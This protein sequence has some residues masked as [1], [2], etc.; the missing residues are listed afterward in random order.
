MEK[1]AVSGIML[2]MLLIGMLTLAFNT[3][4]V[5]ASGTIYIRAD[6]SIEPSDAPISVMDNV[7]YILTDNI[8]SS[9]DG[10]VVERN[11]ILIDGRSCV[12][13]GTGSG[14]GISLFH[15]NNVTIRNVTIKAFQYG[16]LLNCSSNS[17][18]AENFIIANDVAGIKLINSSNNKIERNNLLNNFYGI[19]LLYAS[20]NSISRNNLL[21][22]LSAILLCSS[23]DNKITENEIIANHDCSIWIGDSSNNFVA[24]NNIAANKLYGIWIVRS[25]ENILK[26]NNITSN[27]YGIWS[28]Y[29]SNNKFYHNNFINNTKQ[30]NIF[31]DGKNIWDDGYPSGG[32]Y[33]SDYTDCDFYRGP[34]QNETGSDGIGDTPYVIYENNQDNYP[35]KKPY[36]WKAGDFGTVTGGY[37]DFD[38]QVDYQDLFLFRKA[39]VEQYHPLCDLDGDHDVD[40]MDLFQF[41]QCYIKS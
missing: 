10:I 1:K 25:S 32:N 12:V 8:T 39:Y 38:N 7:T 5:K 36:G 20:N 34:Y 22:T 31:E 33:W 3:H 29:S 2:A 23:S 16:I 24:R 27:P 28:V 41:R 21:N 37:Y 40:Y 9:G 30:V 19:W 17:I 13:Q 14:T 26:E 4:P 11:D 35:L 15:R 18:I 6:G